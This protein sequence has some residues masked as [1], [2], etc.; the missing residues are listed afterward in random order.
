M[1]IIAIVV[2][3]LMA[4]AGL[5]AFAVLCLG[6]RREDKAASFPKKAPGFAV[7]QARRFTGLRS[8]AAGPSAIREQAANTARER[9]RADA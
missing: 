2:P 1:L 5:L 8:P 4:I 9:A 7:R 6:I 3:G